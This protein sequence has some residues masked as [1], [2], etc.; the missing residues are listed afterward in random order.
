MRRPNILILHTDQQR[1]DALRAAG[2]PDIRTPS[3]DRL[4]AEGV[5]YLRHYVQSPVS[6]P[7]RASFLTGQYGSTLGC[8]DNGIPVPIDAPTLPRLLKPYGYTSA[9]VGKLH[10]QPHA[11]RDHR[12][13]HPDYGFD[14]LELS[15]EPGCYEDAYRA[16]VRRQAPE[17]LDAVSVGLPP[18]TNI[19]QRTM[20]VDDGIRHPEER[21]PKRPVPFEAPSELTHTAFVAE[22]TIEFLRRHKAREPFFMFSGFYSPHD[23][24]VVPQ[25]FL[26]LY[27]PKTLAV[28]EF[29]PEM[30]AK[31]GEAFSDEVLRGAR[32]GYYAM[33][34]EVDH[35]VGRVLAE[36]EALGL[37]QETI[38]V[39]TSDHGDWLGEHLRWGKGYPGHDCIT[40]TPL[41]V[42]WPAG[43]E[44]RGV[45]V[46]N[47]V[48]AL[49]VLPALL[50][51]S[52]IPVPPHVQGRPLP[53]EAD[54]G[55]RMMALTEQASW[56]TLRTP[57]LRYVLCASS[58]E[59]LYDLDKDP[60]GYR[61]LAGDPQYA[62][63][64]ATFRGELARRLIEMEQPHRRVWPY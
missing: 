36:L 30:D 62:D 35:H 4:A 23:P 61:D 40:R 54:G 55:H 24:W 57:G 33:V 7:S 5:N 64:V 48:E 12:E 32:Q 51:W 39:F 50:E 26:D 42:R 20:H 10:F 19:W 63:L 41:L 53:T 49:D 47:I 21:F 1:G 46:E 37:A 25:E 34:S 22:Q 27:D 60:G 14:H 38:V 15:D 16:W 2:N 28:P 13:A 11:C 3:L 43:L 44:A 17:H 58:H 45:E 59:E 31:R 56:K 52:G 29:P 9:L 18:A 6:M 8:T